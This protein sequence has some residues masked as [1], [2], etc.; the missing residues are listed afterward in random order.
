MTGHR[1]LGYGTVRSPATYRDMAIRSVTR[2]MVE[3]GSGVGL[4]CLVSA[5]VIAQVRVGRGIALDLVRRWQ[6]PAGP[7]VRQPDIIIADFRA[8]CL[9]ATCRP[10]HRDAVGQGVSIRW[11]RRTGPK[12]GP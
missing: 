3:N 1:S 11:V 5:V 4:L 7:S 10:G 2:G 12:A 9:P 8:G 6:A